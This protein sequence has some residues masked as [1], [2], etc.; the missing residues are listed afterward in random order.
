MRA[1]GEGRGLRSPAQERDTK[2]LWKPS[3][4]RWGWGKRIRF[5]DQEGGLQNRSP[6]SK[7]EA[8][9]A[10]YAGSS[11]SCR[12]GQALGDLK[13]SKTRGAARSI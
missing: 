12:E 8:E 3:G 10:G 4:Q 7:E 1:G 5:G 13:R 6:G 11:P 2:G 9:G